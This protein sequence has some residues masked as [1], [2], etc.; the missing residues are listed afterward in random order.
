MHLVVPIK[1][2]LCVWRLTGDSGGTYLL[3][4][5]LVHNKTKGIETYSFSTPFGYFLAT[6]S[7]YHKRSSILQRHIKS[8]GFLQCFLYVRPGRIELPTNPWQGL[9]IPLNH[10]RKTVFIWKALL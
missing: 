8:T 6:L 1:V 10:G 4:G 3:G 5:K 7:K 2:V 9:V